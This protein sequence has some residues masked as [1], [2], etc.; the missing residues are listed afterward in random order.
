MPQF[1]IGFQLSHDIDWFARINGISIHAM[2]FGGRLPD[3]LDR[4][5]NT[6]ILLNVYRIEPFIHQI[7][8]NDEYISKRLRLLDD[9]D[10]A[11]TKR[12]RYLRHFKEMASRGFW[13]FDRD[14]N[15][16]NVYHLIAMP[17]DDYDAIYMLI[18]LPLLDEKIKIGGNKDTLV[19]T[20]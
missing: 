12:E 5:W 19:L 13:S 2:S 10:N 14:L 15:E 7:S 20:I 16:S 1:S 11:D 9:P 4:D 3:G 6:E 17:V 18:D 8:Y